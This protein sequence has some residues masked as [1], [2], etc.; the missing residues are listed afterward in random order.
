MKQASNAGKCGS[1]LNPSQN[2][3]PL[4]Y[5]SEIPIGIAERFSTYATLSIHVFSFK[6][7]VLRKTDTLDNPEHKQITSAC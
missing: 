6:S 2:A 5:K 3:T 1:K 7:S 4:H